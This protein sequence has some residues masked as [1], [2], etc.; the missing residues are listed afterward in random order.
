MFASVPACSVDDIPDLD[1]VANV[2]DIADQP[3]QPAYTG[4]RKRTAHAATVRCFDSFGKFKRAMV[5]TG[6]KSRYQQTEWHHIVLKK[7]E[8]SWKLPE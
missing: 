8:I 7:L 2:G 3:T 4:P 6:N 1:D 5:K